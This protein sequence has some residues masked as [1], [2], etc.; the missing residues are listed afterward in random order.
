MFNVLTVYYAFIL[1]FTVLFGG[2]ER[3]VSQRARKRGEMGLKVV[4]Y[5]V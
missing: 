1:Q 3:V 4:P 5:T 2:P